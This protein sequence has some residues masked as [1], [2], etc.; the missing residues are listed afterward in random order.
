MQILRLFLCLFVGCFLIRHVRSQNLVKTGPKT[1]FVIRSYWKHGFL[2][3]DGSLKA[4][5]KSLQAQTLTNWEAHIVVVDNKPFTDLYNIIDDI[6]DSRINVFS[7][8]IRDRYK[9]RDK[10][11]NW[12]KEYHPHLY[13]GTDSAVYIGCSP[14]A[15]WLVVTN[16]DNLYGESFIQVLSEVES[17]VDVV[18][19]DYYSRYQNIS[20]KACDRFRF[21]PALSAAAGASLPPT[22]ALTTRLPPFSPRCKQNFFSMCHTDAAASAIRLPRFRKESRAFGEFRDPS[23]FGLH[24]GF[25]AMALRKAQW[26]VLRLRDAGLVNHGPSPQQCAALGHVWDDSDVDSASAAGGSCL[27]IHEAAQKLGGSMQDPERLQAEVDAAVVEG[28]TNPALAL[29]REDS[30]GKK[31]KKR[32]KKKEENEEG[33]NKEGQGNSQE[34]ENLKGKKR[35]KDQVEKDKGDSNFELVRVPLAPY[36]IGQRRFWSSMDHGNFGEGVYT[37]EITT[38]TDEE[39]V[40]EEGA[41]DK[42]GVDKKLTPKS[43]SRQIRDSGVGVPI[44]TCLRKKKTHR[45]S[46]FT[47]LLCQD[48][49]PH[50]VISTIQL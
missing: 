38:E 41:A 49:S 35:G 39:G 18:A 10:G 9:P 40:S 7:F 31:R 11:G 19:F 13:N 3:G 30:G 27:N 28:M 5:L 12:E 21:R 33:E 16:G 23:G 44:L 34:D 46:M 22:T 2:H 32:S 47:G 1:C 17:S 4:L 20:G 50:N 25:L 29:N 45:S 42:K 15:E 8:W 48:D 14:D 24:D 36:V 43:K 6:S 37:P 26:R